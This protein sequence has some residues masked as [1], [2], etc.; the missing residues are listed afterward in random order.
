MTY[1]PAS[2]AWVRLSN[3]GEPK[4]TRN[5]K[6]DDTWVIRRSDIQILAKALLGLP[7]SSEGYLFGGQRQSL[8]RNLLCSSGAECIRL[9]SRIAEKHQHLGLKDDDEQDLTARIETSLMLGSKSTWSRIAGESFV[10]LEAKLKS[11]T[12]R[13]PVASDMIG[14]L[15]LTNVVF[16]NAHAPTSET[17]GSAF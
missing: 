2:S 11:L 1:V 6:N 9:L 3:P 12:S 7:W 8:C 13:Q 17:P 10:T 15:V 5:R 4:S 16:R 14:I